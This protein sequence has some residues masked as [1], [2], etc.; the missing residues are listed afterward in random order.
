MKHYYSLIINSFI[1]FLFILF[2]SFVKEYAPN[3]GIGNLQQEDSLTTATI[4][5]GGDAMMHMPQINA[6][7]IDSSKSYDYSS[8]FTEISPILKEG[9][10]NIINLETTLAGHPYKGYPQ[11]CAP[12]IYAKNLYDAGF[13]F[14]VLANNHTVD[15]G[16]K[17][18]ERTINTLTD[19]GIP[20][21]GSFK[22]QA[23][24]DSIYP[25]LLRVNGIRISLL[26]CTYGTNG[27]I[28]PTPYLVNMIDTVELKKDIQ[29]AKMDRPDILMIAIHWGDEY[30]REPGAYQKSVANFLI[31]NGVDIIIGSHPHVI[32]PI[33]IVERN[34]KQHLIIWSLGNFVSNQR[35]HYTDGGMMVKFDLVKHKRKMQT[36]FQKIEYIPMWVYKTPPPIEYRILPIYLYENEAEKMSAQ[37]KTLFLRFIE[38]SRS[39]LERD[40]RITEYFPNY[41]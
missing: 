11:F 12:D 2:S 35:R 9:N 6:G 27:L 18:M 22:S 34:D 25:V 16:G 31:R 37:D 3:W 5:V 19:F 29:K 30:K 38:D 23:E 1:T 41:Q 20:N 32:Q 14:F 26:N 17:G 24:R 33:E 13:N 28:P 4:I 39:H 10:L 36:K 15:R 8:W 40:E 21:T 7:Y